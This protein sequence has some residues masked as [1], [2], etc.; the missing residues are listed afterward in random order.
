MDDR[1]GSPGRGGGERERERP[2]DFGPPGGGG[3]GG[4]YG[5]PPPGG[6]GEEGE[7]AKLYIG[8]I[9]Y[10]VRGLG[11]AGA[12]REEGCSLSVSRFSNPPKVRSLLQLY[13]GW[14]DNPGNPRASGWE[15]WPY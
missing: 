12:Q 5:G 6:G 9:S 3:G 2:S 14:T 8:N 7:P 15:V 11:A 4:G 13:A 1:G 10:S